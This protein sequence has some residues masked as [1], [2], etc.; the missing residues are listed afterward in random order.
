MSIR[1]AASCFAAFVCIGCGIEGRT[2]DTYSASY[3]ITIDRT[4]DEALSGKVS[5]VRE[6]TFAQFAWSQSAAAAQARLQIDSVLFSRDGRHVEVGPSTRPVAAFSYHIL[7]SGT[8]VLDSAPADLVENPYLATVILE[9]PMVRA[10]ILPSQCRIGTSWDDSTVAGPVPVP[11]VEA[12]TSIYRTLFSVDSSVADTVIVH[13]RTDVSTI[14]LAGKAQVMR[15][16]EHRE[17]RWRYADRCRGAATA[18]ESGRLTLIYV[19]GSGA[20]PDTV[21]VE[22]RRK[23][24][25]TGP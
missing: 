5:T 16:S 8:F 12:A 7:A 19:G 22:E 24:V 9:L 2:S 13:T 14:G 15:G 3:P 21:T 4:S 23:V 20:A 1:Y 6:Q 25:R 11:G 10:R 17:T 18:Q